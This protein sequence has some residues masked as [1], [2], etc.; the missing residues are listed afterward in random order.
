[1]PVLG[2]RGSGSFT[3]TGQRPENWRQ[4]ILRLYPN[5]SAPLTA[6]LSM[7]KSE[8]T[9][10]PIFHWFEKDLPDERVFI[11]NAA[12]YTA[13]DTV[14]KVDDGNGNGLARICPRGVVLMHES[15]EEIMWVTQDPTDDDTIYV[16]RGMGEV[17]AGSL[18]DDDALY[19]IG[20]AYEQGA[21]VPTAVGYDP[22]EKRNYCQIERVPLALTRT[23]MRTRLRTGDS[24]EQAK[25]EALD[26]VAMRME[27]ALIFGQMKSSTVNGKLKM[28]TRGI[29]RWLTT[30][31]FTPSGGILTEDLWDG[32]LKD[33]FR[34]GSANKIAFCGAT[35]LNAL[36]GLVK[37]KATINVVPGDDS[38]GMALQEYI[39]P[40]GVLYLKLH[41]LFTIHPVYTKDCLVV[42]LNNIVWRYIDD[43]QFLKYRQDPGEDGR[44]DE[45]LVEH[46]LE[47]RHEKTHALIKGVTTYS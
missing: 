25:L 13:T 10:D 8:P 38:Y 43:L 46:G 7:L 29:R 2:M 34:Y 20:S 17:A 32:Y 3:V 14:L 24:Y 26:I 35:F 1:M 5:G 4:M 19:I 15:S 40:F 33:I 6:I 47:L 39:T 37:S 21:G 27:K 45:F 44:K 42:D 41:P 36:N 12:G 30:N 28:T 11:N 9:D 23:A 31:V 18:S 22:V 16:A